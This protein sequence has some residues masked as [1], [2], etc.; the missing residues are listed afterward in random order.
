MRTFRYSYG[1]EN[2]V[3]I[4]KEPKVPEVISWLE[5]QKQKVG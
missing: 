1:I 2:L 5:Q 4:E 3:H